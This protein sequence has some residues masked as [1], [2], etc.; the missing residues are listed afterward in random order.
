LRK[1]GATAYFEKSK[2]RLD[3]DSQPLIEVVKEVL[4]HPQK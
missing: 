3:A 1:D 4:A 2:L